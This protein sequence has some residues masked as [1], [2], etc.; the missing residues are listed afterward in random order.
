MALVRAGH[1]QP[2]RAKV[3]RRFEVVLQDRGDAALTPCR[4]HPGLRLSSPLRG[5]TGCGSSLEP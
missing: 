5:G 2:T 1:V 4:K 3:R